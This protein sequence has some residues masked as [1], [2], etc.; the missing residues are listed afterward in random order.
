MR[1]G[2]LRV[3]RSKSTLFSQS[4]SGRFSQTAGFAALES[5]IIRSYRDLGLGLKT[6]R[7]RH[8]SRRT[9]SSSGLGDGLLKFEF[10]PVEIQAGRTDVESVLWQG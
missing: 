2:L 3:D 9:L 4:A 1:A 6:E 7:V 10:E 5:E 8:G